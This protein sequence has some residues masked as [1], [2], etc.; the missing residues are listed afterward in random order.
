MT[1][2]GIAKL[3]QKDRSESFILYLDIDLEVR[4]A[5]MQNRN[6]A[7]SVER[8]L[9]TDS[10]DFSDFVNFDLSITDPSYKITD[11]IW[12]DPSYYK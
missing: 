11:E 1:P 9:K 7:D 2:S 3:H 10:E 4:R 12:S 5:R 6:D 8:R